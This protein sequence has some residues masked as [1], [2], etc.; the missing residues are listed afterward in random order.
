MKL[1]EEEGLDKK[2]RPSHLQEFIGHEAIKTRLNI[3]IGAAKSRDEPLPHILFHGPPGLGKTT[4][5]LILSKEMNCSIIQTSGPAIDKPADLAG[6][7]TNLCKG[8][9][10][11]IDEIHRLP[12]NVEEY[13]YQAME[14]FKIDIMI[15]SGPTAKSVSIAIKPF[16]LVAAT[17]K[18]G[19]LS[20]PL[21]TR[22]P[23]N[24]R[25]DFYDVDSL[26]KIAKRSADVL[27]VK[28]E[29]CAAQELAMR[30]RGTPRIVNNLLRW[31]RDCHTNNSGAI[32]KSDAETALDMLSIDK[33]GLDEMDIRILSW[34][35]D[36]HGGGPVGL[37]S[38]AIAMGEDADTIEQVQEPFL[39]IKG[40]I[41]RGPQGRV[42][43]DLAYRHLGR[44]ES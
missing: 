40:Y 17:T 26:I 37:K 13:L 25:L 35:I 34:I 29:N 22:F 18:T 4:L 16:T 1:L 42:A 30:S 23:F 11:F 9:I 2:I 38:I 10:L 28:I 19:L 20:A 5:S 21:R 3:L 27:K 15:D 31:V 43:T 33:K 32:K 41:K 36:H 12:K 6:I 44:S 7:L 24:V 8:D 14:D 39:V